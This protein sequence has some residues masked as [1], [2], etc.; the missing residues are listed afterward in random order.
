MLFSEHIDTLAASGAI[1]A[2]AW[3][4]MRI[5]VVGQLGRGLLYYVRD[6]QQITVDPDGTVIV[7]WCEYR[8]CGKEQKAHNLKVTA[9]LELHCGGV[10]LGRSRKEAVDMGMV[11]IAVADFDGKAGGQ[12]NLAVRDTAA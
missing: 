7:S 6:S 10:F 8:S 4:G 3:L 1:L 5:V 12:R 9:T 2:D 11:V